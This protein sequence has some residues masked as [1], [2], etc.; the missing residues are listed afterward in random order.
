MDR[1]LKALRRNGF[2]AEFFRDKNSVKGWILEELKGFETIGVGGSV[3]IRELGI[4]NELK[5]EGKQVLD[6][7]EGGLSQ[8]EI[9]SIRK[10]HLTC[11]AFLTSV[12]ALTQ[13][14]ILV[15]MDGIGNRVAA[16][17]FGP[18]KVFIV[19][20][21]NKIVEDVHKAV[22]RIKDVAAPKNAKRFGL[23]DLPCVKVGRCVDCNHPYRICRA[24]VILEKRPMLTDVIVCLVDEE[25]GY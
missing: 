10:R 8:D 13:D 11:D 1:V 15:S 2:S 17:I 20:G 22:R 3:T 25:L 6:H 23:K 14:G 16:M 12:N 5:G 9:I 18:K 7:W 4:L 24:L 21:R 19:A